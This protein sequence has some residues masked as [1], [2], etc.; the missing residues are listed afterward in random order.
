MG[1]N[2]KRIVIGM[3]IAALFAGNAFSK[4]EK[5]AKKIKYPA[6]EKTSPMKNAEADWYDNIVIDNPYLRDSFGDNGRIIRDKIFIINQTDKDLNILIKGLSSGDYSYTDGDFLRSLAE[7]SISAGEAQGLQ[8]SLDSYLYLIISL[9]GQT[10]ITK[11]QA[12]TRSHDLY[13]YIQEVA[14]KTDPVYEEMTL[15]QWNNLDVETALYPKIDSGTLKGVFLKNVTINKPDSRSFSK[16]SKQIEKDRDYT[17]YYNFDKAHFW[18]NKR[19]TW[20]EKIDGLRSVEEIEAEKASAEAKAKAEKQ[21]A[22]DEKIKMITKDYVYHGEDEASQNA[23]LF[24]A[25]ALEKGHAYYIKSFM[26][27]GSGSLGGAVTSLF[28]DPNYVYIEYASQKV[29]G[30]AVNASQTIFGS[31]PVTVIVAG[32]SVPVVLCLV[33]KM[34]DL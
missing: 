14:P 34:F 31:Q 25:K 30:E 11:F 9:S 24:S 20:V 2:L 4:T 17:I 29:R 13:F 26:I 3:L 23:S 15:D 8:G 16:W 27:Y 18:N 22:I 5:K 21:K 12:G 6:Y 1:G 32:G 28:K 33:D 10:K 7:T 19:V